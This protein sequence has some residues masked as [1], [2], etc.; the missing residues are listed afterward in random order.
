M[1]TRSPHDDPL[2]GVR[3]AVG[4][5]TLALAVVGALVAVLTAFLPGSPII[6]GALAGWL[7]RETPRQGA[8]IGALAGLLFALPAV[9]FATLFVGIFLGASLFGAMPT[10][11]GL[12]L[13]IVFGA[14]LAYTAG[15]GAV[16]GYL[17]VVAYQ[18][19][20]G[21]AE[22]TDADDVGGARSRDGQFDDTQF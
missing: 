22:P 1:T 12:I 8:T 19:R 10:A 3:D 6:G 21:P 9:L 14:G 15:L 18:R 16:G 13:F 2:Q 17:G 11:F 7:H 4:T 5:S 20:Y